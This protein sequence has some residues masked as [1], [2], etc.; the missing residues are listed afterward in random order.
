[1]A[2]S[3][4]SVEGAFDTSGAR[5]QLGHVLELL[6]V[7]I[8]VASIL[9]MF[10][11]R[12]G[13]FDAITIWACSS[14]ATYAYSRLSAGGG[15]GDGDGVPSWHIVL[16]LGVALLF[17]LP[18]FEWILGGQDQGVY[19]NMAMELVRTGALQP[20][21]HVLPVI[22]DPQAR[23]L[24]MRDNYASGY[25]PGVYG[26]G[27]L[28]FQF[29]HLFPIWLALFAFGDDPG[30]A[31]YGLTFLSLISILAFYRLAHLLTGDRKVGLVAGLLLAANPLHAFFSKFPVTEVPT[32]AFS[33]LSFGFLAAYWH[34][35]RGGGTPRAALLALSVTTM[36]LVFMTRI[37]GFMYLPFVYALSLAALLYRDAPSPRRG[38]VIWALA[39]GWLYTFSVLYGLKWSRPYSLDIYQISFSR[40][41]GARWSVVLGLGAVVALASWLAVATASRYE[42]PSA[43][44][45]RA[46]HLVLAVLP[47]F[48]IVLLA[49]GLYKAYKLG[50]TDA[51]AAN[52]WE[53]RRYRLAGSGWRGFFSTSITAS[54][55]YLSPFIW[56]ALAACMFLV[57]TTAL[58]VLL[59]FVV[60][61]IGYLAALQWVVPYQPYYARYLLSEFVPYALLLVVCVW[62]SLPKRA[63]ARRMLSIA[64][65]VGFV[66]SAGLSA[67]QLRKVEHDGVSES[68]DRLVHGMDSGDAIVVVSPFCCNLAQRLATTLNYTKGLNVVRANSRDPRFRT[69]LD[70]LASKY[71]ELYLLTDASLQQVGGSDLV[72]TI[73]LKD[74]AFRH[75]VLPPIAVHKG[76]TPLQLYL[77]T[78]RNRVLFGRNASGAVKLLEGWSDRESWGVWT[79]GARAGLQIDTELDSEPGGAADYGIQ[80]YGRAFVTPGHPMQRIR[81]EI[82]GVLF[83]EV[84]A[85]TEQP[86]FSIL[87]P[88]TFFDSKKSITIEIITPD[89]I[90]PSSLGLSSDGRVLGYGLQSVTIE[91]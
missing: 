46:T 19:V 53:G 78:S 15:R 1:M 4:A 39:V 62:G 23:A 22:T 13:K 76:N 24:Y 27:A 89:A 54:V 57:R 64:L 38:L 80:L 73:R 45:K 67:M 69:L 60:P 8:V 55:V 3:A 17:R 11:L 43:F 31:V 26:S 74:A 63:Q 35:V 49:F 9:G 70:E 86:T 28:T 59:I 84:D 91:D 61:F 12:M 5:L 88:S 79:N 20:I 2:S 21:D 44:L 42:R 34:E 51:Y 47:V 82:D 50:F 77:Y 85:T 65:F 6:S 18:P 29:Y 66:W 72:R 7:F 75:G 87:I 52:P 56:G 71:D 25:L 81:F 37:S 14:L 36:G 58:R 33:L 68:I 90:S 32:L 40:A 16:I 41:L 48:G 30:R 83:Q 10:E